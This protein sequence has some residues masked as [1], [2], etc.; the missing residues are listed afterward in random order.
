MTPPATLACDPGRKGAIALLCGE[1]L[2]IWPQPMVWTRRGASQKPLTDLPAL[3]SLLLAIASVYEI[4]EAF[5]EKVWGVRGQGAS[6]G[7]ALAH[8]RCALETACVFLDIKYTLV[9][10]NRWKAD[11]GLYNK[12]KAAALELAI[13]TFPNAAHYFRPIRGVRDTESAIGFADAALIA[14]HGMKHADR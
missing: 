1:N 7:A 6:T 5:V 14:F 12:P 4:R 10:P 13:K 8:H 2:H 11:L 9:S 3:R